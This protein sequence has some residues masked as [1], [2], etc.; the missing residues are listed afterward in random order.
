MRAIV[1]GLVAALLG[2]SRELPADCK[3]HAET[4]CA[5]CG[6]SSYA[7]DDVRASMQLGL[8]SGLATPE[9]CKTDLDKH[10]RN[11][12]LAGGVAS[13]CSMANAKQNFNNAH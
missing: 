5:E 3:K 12:K 4:V 1:I 10:A 13:W 2:C 7:C 9:Q 6:E 11:I 8:K